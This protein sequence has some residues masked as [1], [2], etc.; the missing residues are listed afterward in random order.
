MNLDLDDEQFEKQLGK[1]LRNRGFLFA[2]NEDEV[3]AFESRMEKENIQ[4]P[5]QV[6]DIEMI[7]SKRT[8]GKLKRL[9]AHDSEIQ[10]NLAQAAREGKSIDEQTAKKMQQDRDNAQ[11]LD[12]SPNKDTI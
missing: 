12:N 8:K 10:Q 5:D 6:F 2:T 1:T 4:I 7:L 3:D 9:E 11:K